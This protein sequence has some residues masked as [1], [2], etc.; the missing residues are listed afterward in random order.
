MYYS[1]SLLAAILAMFTKETSIT[2]GLMVVLY[3]ISFF[4]T[5]KNLNWGYLTPFLLTLLVIPLTLLLSGSE[6]LWA[7]H[8]R[9]VPTFFTN[10]SPAQ[11]LLTEFRVALTYMRLEFLPIHQNLDYDY[12]L[13]KSIFE[14]PTLLSFL[15]LV[16]ILFSS[17]RI[18]SKYR[19]VSFSIFWFF[20]TLLPESS[21]F[22]FE[23]VIFEHRLY[24]L[25]VGYSLFLV[26]GLYYF[27][28]S[29]PEGRRILKPFKILRF[30]Q[31]DIRPMVA[32]LL[33][34]IACNSFLTFQR[35][36]IWKD[37]FTLWN[38]VVE[39]SPHKARAHNNRGLEYSNQGNFNQ[40]ISDFNKAIE[41]N[42]GYAEAY[43]NLGGV[44]DKKGDYVHALSDFNRSIKI[45]PD[46]AEAYYNRGTDYAKQNNFIQAMSDYTKAI[47]IDPDYAHAY[48]NR[49]VIYAEQG[50]RLQALSDFNKAI[51]IDPEYADAY[52]NRA[53]A[54]SNN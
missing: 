20:L 50:K 38:D 35:N 2:L 39:K 31:D 42:P 6:K 17:L 26:S 48:N 23:D 28:H 33:I 53:E 14:V 18:F 19:L 12:P 8:S 21:L 16:I 25:M 22:P 46:Y 37:E 52:K 34:I 10:I 27:C 5:N 44:Y 30:A 40:A 47:E 1:F 15:F 51:E 45:A 7:T 3:E 11:Y 41:I 36:K 32:F 43:N 4:K 9:P 13:S 54:E 49:G 29:E 24:L